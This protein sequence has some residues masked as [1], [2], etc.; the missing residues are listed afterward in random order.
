MGEME[1]HYKADEEI[2]QE[3]TESDL[4]EEYETTNDAK[5]NNDSSSMDYESSEEKKKSRTLREKTRKA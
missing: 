1:D 3:E 4:S 5:S 2:F